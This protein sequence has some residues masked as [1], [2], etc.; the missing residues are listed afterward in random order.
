MHSDL[1]AEER[2]TVINSRAL[3]LN[4]L[5]SRLM[6]VLAYRHHYSMFIIVGGIRHDCRPGI[7]WSSDSTLSVTGRAMFDECPSV[8]WGGGSE[9][10]DKAKR[11]L[12][13]CRPTRHSTS[14]HVTFRSTSALPSLFVLFFSLFSLL[15]SPLS[16]TPW[17][18]SD[19][20]WNL[21]CLAIRRGFTDCSVLLFAVQTILFYF[22][23]INHI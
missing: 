6:A 3:C 17:H 8:T 18:P 12:P 20:H 7:D 13:I 11:R 1:C 15:F 2:L 9:T 5:S 19:W 22:Y 21:A 23:Y 10:C 16:P 14:C 4:S